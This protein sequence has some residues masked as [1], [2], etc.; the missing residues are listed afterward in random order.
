MDIWRLL[1]SILIF[2]SINIL[3]Q[4][5]GE[6]YSQNE[7]GGI[8]FI[9][10]KTWKGEPTNH[11]PYSFHLEWYFPTNSVRVDMHGPFFNDPPAPTEPVS[12]YFNKLYN[13][14]C[15]EIFFLNDKNHYLEV[16]I[17]PRGHW[18]VLLLNRSRQSF[19]DGKDLNMTVRNILGKDT[20]NSIFEIPL[21]YFPP[22][23]TKYNAYAIHGSDPNREYQALYKVSNGSEEKPDF[24]RLQYFQPIDIG[25]IVP[26][27]LN[28][29]SFSDSVHGDLWK[30]VE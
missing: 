15:V 6:N 11:T 3:A 25:K 22:N 28:K 14:E 21:S 2:Q 30:N 1:A 18:Y 8:D 5:I 29:K 20:W 24:H 10:D 23:V 27:D 4:S 16:E 12:G 26:N 7:P 19:N 13:F 17:G 9:V